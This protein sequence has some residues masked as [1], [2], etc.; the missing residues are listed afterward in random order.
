MDPLV[1]TEGLASANE[2]MSSRS[3]AGSCATVRTSAKPAT[4]EGSA[5]APSN[6]GRYCAWPPRVS[7]KNADRYAVPTA[8]SWDEDS[9]VVVGESRPHTESLADWPPVVQSSAAPG[10]GGVQY[11]LKKSWSAPM[12]QMSER[13]TLS[14]KA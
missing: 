4:F 11:V 14:L 1:V 10:N 6:M 2:V 5:P 3:A 9:R 8:Y 13:S 12:T 7:W